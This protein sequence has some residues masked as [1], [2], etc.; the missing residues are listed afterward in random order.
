MKQDNQSGS[1]PAEGANRSEVESEFESAYEQL[2]AGAVEYELRAQLSGSRARI[3]MAQV[4][5]DFC[6]V[7]TYSESEDPKALE[8]FERVEKH[9]ASLRQH[10]G[11]R[12]AEAKRTPVEVLE[13]LSDALA[14]YFKEVATPAAAAGVC[15]ICQRSMEIGAAVTSATSW[16]GDARL[17]HIECANDSRAGRMVDEIQVHLCDEAGGEVLHAEEW[18]RA[19]SEG[20]RKE[21]TDAIQVQL[22]NDRLLE[23]TRQRDAGDLLARYLRVVLRVLGLTEP[24]DALDAFRRRKDRATIRAAELSSTSDAR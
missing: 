17:A 10:L 5:R 14:P 20:A 6:E 2:F 24:E 9:S 15:G 18:N 13:D 16:N 7:L 8:F 22:I 11:L 19:L 12:R 23:Q 3:R 21:L 4:L 1:Q